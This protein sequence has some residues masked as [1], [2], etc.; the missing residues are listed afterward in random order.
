MKKFIE[1]FEEVGRKRAIHQLQSMGFYK[2]AKA[3]AKQE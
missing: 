1:Y 2:E 3:L